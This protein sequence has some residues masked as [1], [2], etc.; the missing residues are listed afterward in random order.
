MLSLL[1]S[2]LRKHSR[3]DSVPLPKF[4]G[5]QETRLRCACLWVSL[6]SP[7]RTLTLEEIA[8]VMGI[9]RERV[10][11]IEAGALRKLRHPSRIIISNE[12][13]N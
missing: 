1:L 13:K 11:Q 2:K 9:T 4:N 5:N 7:G 10:R 12:L 6:H 8:E 3:R